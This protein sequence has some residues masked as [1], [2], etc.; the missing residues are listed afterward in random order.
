MMMQLHHLPIL[1]VTQGVPT[2]SLDCVVLGTWSDLQMQT[3]CSHY[4]QPFSQHYT[5]GMLTSVK[6]YVN[7]LRNIGAH[8]YMVLISH[9]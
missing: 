8:E 6:L 1:N 9:L 4:S 7:H 3:Y 2:I 5:W